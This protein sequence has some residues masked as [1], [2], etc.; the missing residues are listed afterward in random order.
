MFV[1]LDAGRARFDIAR[2]AANIKH[3]TYGAAACPVNA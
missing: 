1:R 2:V 3:S